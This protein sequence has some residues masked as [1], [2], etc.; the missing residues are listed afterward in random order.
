MATLQQNIGWPIGDDRVYELEVLQKDGKAISDPTK[1]PQDITGWMLA[2][3]VAADEDATT[4]LIEKRTEALGITIIGTYNPVRA[5]NTQRVN[6]GIYD[7]DTD[8]GSNI[9]GI[10]GTYVQAL[11]RMD[12]TLEATLLRGK[13]VLTKSAA[14]AM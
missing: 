6:I 13:V 4:Y 14:P 2:W 7:S 1:A 10:P 3:V 5:L 12:P 9:N 11:K 8:E